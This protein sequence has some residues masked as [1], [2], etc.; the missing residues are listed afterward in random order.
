MDPLDVIQRLTAP[1]PPGAAAALERTLTRVPFVRGQIEAQYTRL[2]ADLEP[3]LKPYRDDAP[4]YTE[5]PPHGLDRAEVLR[6]MTALRERE[7][8]HWKAGYISGA[9]YQGDD[10]HIAF[11]NEVYA[12][13]AQ[14]NPLHADV[15]PSITKYEAEVV[16]MTA[17]LLNG[18]P[19]VCGTVT[20]GG[21]ESI[22]LAMKTYRDWARA[23]KGIT[24]PEVVAPVTAHAAFDKAAQYFGLRLVHVPI[25]A[26][27]RANLKAVRQAIT[28]N[29]VAVVGSAPGFPHGA[30]DP[31]GELSD[32]TRQRGV[33][34]H[35]DACLGGF[36][37]PFARKL[38][39]P[40]PDFD[41]SLPG[42]TSMSADT[43]KYGYA[44]KGTSVLLYR[45][46]ELRRYQYFA[47]TEWPG[48]LYLSPTIAG[49]RPGA[50]SAAAWAAMVSLGEAGYLDATRRILD[51]AAAIR[52]GVEAIP[53][54]SLLGNP[55]FVIAMTSRTLN[56]Y[57]VLDVM[58]QRGWHLI[59]L[60]KPP[61]MH[62]VVT[63]R[64]T[65]PGVAERFLADLRDAVAQVR[66]TPAA[67]G[68][69]A[70]VYGMAASLPLRGIVKG[71]LQRYLDVLY[72]V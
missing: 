69:M 56:I 58:T 15:W 64:H 43:H 38:G 12:L 59:G 24:K 9:V 25:E 22:L 19:G 7:E 72:K 10:E 60:H 53:E 26:D 4:A 48:G 2:M 27:S 17:R 20:S 1:L 71:M 32:L 50:L 45:T 68:G 13:H 41:F 42:V 37:L 49:S 3:A 40:V 5:L 31:I 47:A 18:G 62:L 30:I 16:A 66:E 46:P 39:Y 34:L 8:A 57:R 54:V 33:G 51:T 63:L 14:A 28:K 23:E 29:T 55:L 6:E 36:V 65:Q 11:L 52:Q 21:T 61:G 70:P 44:A 67:Q 35:V